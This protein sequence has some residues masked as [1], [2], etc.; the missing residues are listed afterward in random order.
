MMESRETT[1]G[2]AGSEHHLQ[3]NLHNRHLQLIAIGGAIGT[4]LFMGSGKTISL[5][6]PSVI[7]AYAIIGSM[8]FFMMRAMGELL[9]SN[10]NYKSFVDFNYDLLGPCAGFFTGW[11]Y[12]FCWVVTGIADVVA[13][14][15]YIQFWAPGV[16]L[17]LPGTLCILLLL[18]L[19][20]LTV[21]LF[22]EMEFWFALVKIVAIVSLIVIGVVLIATGFTSPTGA[23]AAVS[24]LWAQGGWFPHGGAGFLAAFQI[25]V[26]AF[27]GI[28]LIGTA[29]AEAKDPERTLPKAINAI[30]IRVIIFYIL[31]LLV[32]MTVTPWNQVVPDRSPFVNLFML[33]GIPIAASLINFVV[34]TSA[35]SSANSGIYSTGRMLYGLSASKLGPRPFAKLSNNNVPA[36][37][38]AYSCVLLFIGV[39]L[40]Y[41]EGDIMKA[42]TIVTT[43]SSI[44]FI[45]VWSLILFAYMRYRKLHPERHARSIFKM[46][47]GVLMCWLVLAFF[48]FVLVIFAQ[49][50]DTLTGLMYAPIW[51]VCLAVCYPFYRKQAIEHRKHTH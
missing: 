14:T 4:G 40:L 2:Q 43:I 6:G 36:N 30:P 9:L 42:F 13:I 1:P 38:L 47:G 21:K 41:Q 10:L 51:F 23:K 22:G 12:W 49:K 24:N 39:L 3:R 20:L 33:I 48:V 16:P 35:A 37:G 34:L 17:W 18:G 11:T 50:A 5:A 31:A 25:A 19:N 26:F 27:V 15:G 46:P 8:L 28:E 29:S 44:C 32:I 45:F 7:F